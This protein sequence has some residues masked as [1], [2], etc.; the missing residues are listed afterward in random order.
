MTDARDHNSWT[1][2]I[3]SGSP[4][5]NFNNKCG[6]KLLTTAKL[7]RLHRWSFGMDNLLLHTLCD[8]CNYLSMFGLKLVHVSKRVH[9][10]A[11]PPINHVIVWNDFIIKPINFEQE[12]LIELI[13]LFSSALSFVWSQ[14]VFWHISISTLQIPRAQVR[15]SR[16]FCHK[17]IQIIVMEA[18]VPDACNHR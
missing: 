13:V 8:V 4:F 18:Y 1:V 17:A 11:P 5:G 9:W 6:V 15:F 7:Q 12:R 3:W 2:N 10:Y 14:I 16:Q